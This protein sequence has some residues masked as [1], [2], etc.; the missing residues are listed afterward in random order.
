MWLSK[1][2]SSG[3]ARSVTG[4]VEGDLI[5]ESGIAGDERWSGL[6]AS[7]QS[8][9]GEAYRLFLKSITPYLYSV[10]R[11][12]TGSDALVDDIVQDALLTVHRVRHTY[13]PGRPVKPWLAAIA[14][15]RSIDAMRRRGRVGA[16]ELHDEAAFETFADPGAN[17]Q[18]AGDSAR[19]LARM[20]SGLSD[21]QKEAVELVKLKEM[22]LADASALSGQSVASLKVNIHRAIKKMR[23]I[24]S[25]GGEE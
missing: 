8:G 17:R 4:A 2:V 20:T 5:N 14:A 18:E 24:A 1:P 9:D 6:L 12:R 23:L 11:R 13:E 7:A 22:S 15:R 10:A 25:R 21:K 16:R 3:R 19:M